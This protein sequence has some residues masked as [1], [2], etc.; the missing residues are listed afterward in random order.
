MRPS[1]Y[2]TKGD[3]LRGSKRGID[4]ARHPIIYI[5]EIDSTFFLG[6]MITHASGYENIPLEDSHF[7]SRGV[8]DDHAQFFVPQ[9]LLKK[10]E[11]GPFELIGKLS[12]DGI[13]LVLNHLEKTEPIY[14]EEYLNS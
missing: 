8:L 10:E 9:F 14:W 13:E 3:I 7:Q 11:W 12:N 5:C 1:N 2:F 4:E 6:S